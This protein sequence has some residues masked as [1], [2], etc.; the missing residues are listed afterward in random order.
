MDPTSWCKLFWLL[1][2]TRTTPLPL[3]GRSLKPWI[4]QMACSGHE[5]TSSYTTLSQPKTTV[6]NKHHDENGK[7]FYWEV[8]PMSYQ[9]A[10]CALIW[11]QSKSPVHWKMGPMSQLSTKSGWSRTRGSCVLLL[12]LSHEELL[13]FIGL[14]RICS[15]FLH[16]PGHRPTVCQLILCSILF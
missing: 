9:F 5:P 16:L 4:L 2:R 3:L 15:I 8:F 13:C 14:R 1:C 7:L 12:P 10:G 11:Q 6:K